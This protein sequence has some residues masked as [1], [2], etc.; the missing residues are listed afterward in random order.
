MSIQSVVPQH[1]GAY[2]CSY[3][4]GGIDTFNL[5]VMGKF[6]SVHMQCQ[7]ISFSFHLQLCPSSKAVYL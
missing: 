6:L 3:G 2:Q 4:N 7:I 5:I 1:E